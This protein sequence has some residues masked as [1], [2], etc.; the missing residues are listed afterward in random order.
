MEIDN[1]IRDIAHSLILDVWEHLKET[2]LDCT[3]NVEVVDSG[4][5]IE[6]KVEVKNGG[7]GRATIN[8][9]PQIYIE[10]L[11]LLSENEL[12]Q[13]ENN[14]NESNYYTA[15]LYWRR[16]LDETTRI[17]LSNMKGEFELVTA[18]QGVLAEHIFT[19]GIGEKNKERLNANWILKDSYKQRKARVDFFREE[20]KKSKVGAKVLFY[21]F[22]EAELKTW[23]KAQRFY[24]QNKASTNVLDFLKLE[25][26]SLPKDLLEQLTDLDPYTSK[27][28]TIALLA[29]ERIVGVKQTG[30]AIS[31]LERYKAESEKE[32]KN[33]PKEVVANEYRI[34]VAYHYQK[35]VENE[36]FLELIGETDSTS[37]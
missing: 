23:K 3:K 6:F 13:I 33:T 8:Y 2:G 27:P 21:P 22:Y 16:R 34:F 10:Q 20:I 1:E 32:F 15:F 28:S 30:K 24:K 5:E 29:T 36:I 37:N 35:E 4:N 25:F 11:I 31:S 7:L 19:E 26:P 12:E 9:S 14:A 17:L 18:Q